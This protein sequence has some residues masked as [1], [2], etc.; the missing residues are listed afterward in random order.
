MARVL[1]CAE[2]REGRIADVSR[3]VVSAGRGIADAYG[4]ELDVLVL[5]G[6]GIGEEAGSLAAFGADRIFVAEDEAFAAYH[7][8]AA[9]RALEAR[10]AE[11][12]YA[13]ILFPASAQGK[14]L[15]PRL[16]AR[17]GRGLATEV[18]EWSV[19]DGGLIVRRPMYAG[20]A[21]ATLRF[22]DPPAIASL[23]PNVFAPER[24]EGNGR[25][26]RI[27]VADEPRT[28]RVVGIE[29]GERDRLDVA[30]ASVIVSGGRGMQDPSNWHLLEE[31]ADALGDGV[32]LGASRAVV[33]A[34]WRPHAEQ[35]G[36]TGKTVS[37]D[38][39]F[40]IGISGAI[41]HLAGM[42]TAR[43]IVAVNKDREA[44]IFKVADYGVVGDLFEI[45]PRLAEEVRKVRGSG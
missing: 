2:T 35:V 33:D 4:G 9:L 39:Y 36:Q 37:P 11:D 18:V 29:R 6:A 22:P 23:R 8:D 16:A 43:T 25:V 20:K 28:I 10:T 1:A 3:E 31:L 26:E 17:L 27:E 42:R 21:I 45:L 7:P 13:A 19:E 34:G 38:L 12:A 44:P 24:R 32:A 14:D 5:G 30:E 15:A 41:Q 40:A